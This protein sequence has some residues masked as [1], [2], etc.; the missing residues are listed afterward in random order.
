MNR[1]LFPEKAPGYRLAASDAR[2]DHVRGVLRARQGDV[3]DVGVVNGPPGRATVTMVS[4]EALEFEVEWGELPPPLPPVE[5]WL[6]LSRPATMKKIL[7]EGTTLGVG[8]FVVFPAGKSDPAYPRSSLWEDDGFRPYL[9]EGAEQAFA[10]R[11]PEVRIF[12]DLETA[13]LE[14]KGEGHR[15]YCLDLYEDPSPWP[16][17]L[18][19]PCALAV[20]PERGWNGKDRNAFRDAGFHSIGLGD[21]VLRVETAAIV[22]LGRLL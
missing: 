4:R 18:S 13:L 1:I 15:R 20:G 12:R 6:G 3:L 7:R 21:R 16:V 9:V 5:L 11:I 8:T 2:L 17:G 19:A 10:T 22:A 14:R